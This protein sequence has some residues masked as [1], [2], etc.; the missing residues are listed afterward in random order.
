MATV[1]RALP[2]VPRVPLTMGTSLPCLTALERKL[3]ANIATTI[4]QKHKAE[5]NSI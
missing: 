5:Q 4:L 3:A 1:P 2:C